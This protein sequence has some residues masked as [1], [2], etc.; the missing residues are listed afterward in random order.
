MKIPNNALVLVVDGHKTLFLRN[1]GEGDNVELVADTHQQKNTDEPSDSAGHSQH[2]THEGDY[3]QLGEDRNATDAA[4]QL[5]VR[6]LAGDFE[7]LVIIAPPKTLGE[8][9][10]HLHKEV[11]NR[12]IMEL[13]K[14]MTD[15]SLSEIATLLSENASPE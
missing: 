10:K 8:L 2:S 11:E 4:G 6:A 3:H 5:K 15:R 12:V 7:A 9:R 13:A 14:E 1:K